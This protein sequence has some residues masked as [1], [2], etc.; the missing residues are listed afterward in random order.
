ML[1][2]TL[3]HFPD[4]TDSHPFLADIA[5]K[6][7]AFFLTDHCE[8]LIDE[9][10]KEEPASLFVT[11]IKKN[12][13]NVINRIIPSTNKKEP[14]SPDS[15]DSGIVDNNPPTAPGLRRNV[16]SPVV[17]YT[18][19]SR[20]S[21]TTRAS[22]EQELIAS[23]VKAN[24]LMD[25]DRGQTELVPSYDAPVPTVTSRG[26]SKLGT[27]IDNNPF[28][29][30]IIFAAA[31]QILR[32]AGNFTITID[33]DVV[34]LVLFASFCLGL[35]TPRPMIGGVDTPPLKRAIHKFSR[36]GRGSPAKL[37]RKSFLPNA[38]GAKKNAETDAVMEETEADESEEGEDEILA[39]SP[40]ER[41][42][43]GAELGSILNRWSEPPCE[44]FNVRGDNYL[45]DRKKVPS[46][47][48]LFPARGM[49]LFLTDTCPENV[50]R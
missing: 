43:E 36:S 6:I 22:D 40:M 32:L 19:K 25:D 41:F 49:D 11:P 50:G 28:M 2:T 12:Y 8:S 18:R 1:E 23:G 24:L 4:E 30:M 3:S 39:K 16:T 26:T 9:K 35:H 37:L 15:Q 29:F 44:T 14:S 13:K 45:S 42:P 38:A 48:F 27:F 20:R 21:F 31:M 5:D 47:P 7:E 46:G 10:E 33:M 17:P 34:L